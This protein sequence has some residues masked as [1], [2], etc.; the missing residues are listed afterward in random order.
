MAAQ[1]VADSL[2]R[3]TLCV[4]PREG[5]LHVFMPPVGMLEDYLELI[6]AIEDTAADLQLPV[7][8]EGYPPPHDTDWRTS[9]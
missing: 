4:E 5:R 1:R 3:T 8:I 2:V 9:R 7:Q 6:K